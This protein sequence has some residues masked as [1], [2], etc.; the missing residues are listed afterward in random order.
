MRQEGSI[1]TLEL[2]D[3]SLIS[4]M[5]LFDALDTVEE[6]CGAELRQYLEGYFA[7]E[8]EPIS[9]DEHLIDVMESVEGILDE[10]ERTVSQKQLNQKDIRYH[11]DRLRATIRRETN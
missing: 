4:P 11:L 9:R 6:Y 5:N 10:M 8:E 1:M 7:D 2:M 3:G